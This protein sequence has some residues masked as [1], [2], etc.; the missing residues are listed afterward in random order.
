MT[1]KT[2]AKWADYPFLASIFIIGPD[3]PV[4]SMRKRGRY[5]SPAMQVRDESYTKITFPMLY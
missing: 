4:S 5:K 1:V 2:E 3:R